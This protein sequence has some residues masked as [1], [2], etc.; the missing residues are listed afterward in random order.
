[1]VKY[2]QAILQIEQSYNYKWRKIDR[3]IDKNN[4]NKVSEVG[5]CCLIYIHP[6]PPSPKEKKR[7]DK[8]GKKDNKNKNK[9]K[10]H[11]TDIH[12]KA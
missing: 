11:T 9:N 5:F 10:I 1:M 4:N 3:T 7:K 8:D 12:R 6:S 2:I